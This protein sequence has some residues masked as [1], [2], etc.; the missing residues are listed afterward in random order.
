MPAV[1]RTGAQRLPMVP[2]VH[3]E[4]CFEAGAPTGGSWNSGETGLEATVRAG[5]AQ[6]RAGGEGAGEES[7]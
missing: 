1:I 2:N 3:W 5:F 7:W 6:A 4:Q